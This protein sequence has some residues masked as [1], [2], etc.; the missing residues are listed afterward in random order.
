MLYQN[1]LFLVFSPVMSFHFLF[2]GVNFWYAEVKK[3]P[4]YILMLGF[5]DFF[6]S[7]E[8]FFYLISKQLGLLLLK[9]VAA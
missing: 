2:L 5:L 6:R 8:L 1:L 9:I 3:W 4:T 7:L